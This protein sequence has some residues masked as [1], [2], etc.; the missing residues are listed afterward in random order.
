MF[1]IL[2]GLS[3]LRAALGVAVLAGT[4]FLLPVAMLAAGMFLVIWSDHD[5]WPIGSQSFLQSFVTG[6]FET[7]QHKLY[8]V[9]L[10]GVGAIEMLKRMERTKQAAWGVPLP[11]FALIGGLML[12]LHSHGTHPAAHKIAL[13]HAVMGTMAIAAG[14]CKL[15][16]ARSQVAGARSGWELAW[17][18]FILMIGVQLL[19]YSE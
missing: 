17:A 13:H 6:D 16:N 18:G 4:R 10:L 19:V 1:V 3:E 5:A 7:V 12:F 14:S 8:A 11:V 9:L 15:I 2:I